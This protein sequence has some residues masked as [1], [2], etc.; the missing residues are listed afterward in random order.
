MRCA[1]IKA[2]ASGYL[3]K[4]SASTQLVTAIRKVAHGRRV[5]QRRSRG[6]AGLEREV[7]K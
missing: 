1:P 7:A 6:G 4:D 3:T 5:H 2:G